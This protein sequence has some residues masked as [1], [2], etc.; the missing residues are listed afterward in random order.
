MREDRGDKMNAS[1][2]RKIKGSFLLFI[3]LLLVQVISSLLTMIVTMILGIFNLVGP[4]PLWQWILNGVLIWL[5][6]FFAGWI[7]PR[8]DQL[9]PDLVAIVLAIWTLM[10]SLLRNISLYFLPQQF[11]GTMLREILQ[12]LYFDSNVRFDSYWDLPIGCFLLSITLGVGL[13]LS[14]KHP[15]ATQVPGRENA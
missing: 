8:T 2:L 1:I 7:M 3:W 10:T 14:R 9:K 13:L 12:A 11:F 6:W 15:K 5:L 4:T